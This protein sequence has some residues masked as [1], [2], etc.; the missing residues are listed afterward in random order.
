MSSPIN[1]QRGFTLIEL[2][3]VVAI[4]GI[5]A[6]IAIP[7]FLTYQAKAKQSEAKVALGA[8]FTSATAYAAENAANG[9]VV[10]AGAIALIPFVPA[11]TSRYTAW[12]DITGTVTP[13][14]YAPGSPT[15]T[16]CT[17]A[18]TGDARSTPVAGATGF[19]AGAE[20]NVD[21]DATCDEWGIND[22][23]NLVNIM[24]DVTG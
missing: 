2:M 7:N 14:P 4:I 19:T 23:R 3:I 5:L 11:G 17:A 22:Q 8:V 24:S 21:S 1:A 12:Y 16:S 6:G 18:P 13:F 20:G 15:P 9:Y 10:P